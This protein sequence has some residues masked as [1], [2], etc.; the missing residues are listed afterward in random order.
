MKIINE[1]LSV[2]DQ[3]RHN[4]NS[5]SFSFAAATLSRLN[6]EVREEIQDVTSKQLRTALTKLQGYEEL[7]EEDLKVIRSWIIG[8]AESYIQM[9]N[10]YNDWLVEFNR[11]QQEI[12]RYNSQGLDQ[13]SLFK[14]YGIVQD[15]MRVAADISNYLEKKERVEKFDR[16]ARGESTGDLGVLVDLLTAKLRLKDL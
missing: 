2:M 5:D 16:A 7:S 12:S 14:L 11:L 8:D 1:V 3:A 15:A 6:A 4:L 9:E 13:Q 10:N